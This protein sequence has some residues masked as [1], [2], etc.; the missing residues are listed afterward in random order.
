MAP[1]RWAAAGADSMVNGGEVD[2]CQAEVVE[3]ARVRAPWGL[4]GRGRGLGRRWDRAV[5]L[6][7]L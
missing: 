6:F 4:T 5:V 7:D 1:S 3:Q 2:L